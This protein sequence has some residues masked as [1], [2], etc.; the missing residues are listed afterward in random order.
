VLSVA[1]ALLL[2]PIVLDS[3]GK[4]WNGI[5][6]VVVSLVGYYG[7]LDGGLR[8]AV[9]H[10]VATYHAR[11]DTE[12]VNRT[13]R[14]AGALLCGPA[15]VALGITALL[16]PRILRWAASDDP[17]SDP[18]DASA[19]L[20]IMGAGF[21]LGFPMVIFSTTIY[22]LQR[23]DLQNLVGIGQLV[24]RVVLTWLVLASGHGIVGLAW[25]TAGTTATGW[26]A[27][28]VL[29]RRV[30]PTLSLS[31]VP[32]TT[33]SA[34]ELFHYGGYNLLVNLGDAILFYTDHLVIGALLRDPVANTYYGNGADLIPYLLAIVNAVTWPLTPHFTSCWATGNAAELK[35]LL[36][37]GTRRTM[38]L[39]SLLGGGLLLLGSDFIALWLGREFVSGRVYPSSAT[40]LS[41][42]AVASLLIASQSCARQ[43]LF[44]MRE[45]RFLGFTA[46]A[47]AAMN[48]GMSIVLA[49]THGIV[50]VAVGT[51]V[52]VALTQ[53]V[54]Q[55]WYVVRTLGLPFSAWLGSVL[56]GS[57]PVLAGLAAAWLLV[58]G[59]DAGSW[60]RFLG[61]AALVATPAIAA[62]W[63]L[64]LRRGEL[65]FR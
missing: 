4:F 65:R 18:G 49:R 35:R 60:P 46:L 3:L 30:F 38:L 43:A 1:A 42:L 39:A 52:A 58:R 64:G 37:D 21:A 51:V 26:I 19:A 53:G 41:I 25:V 23:I 32:M 29:A 33:A 61:K 40:I 28:I 54:V 14:T 48:L 27:S 17:A 24:L 5:W 10:F 11:R 63:L 12:A 59:M 45:V 36:L 55:T 2:K 9:G 16:A 62:G 22:A 15:A 7:L 57:L 13:L 56:R 8:S 47:E 31:S 50:G 20:W 44:A 34:R 6:S